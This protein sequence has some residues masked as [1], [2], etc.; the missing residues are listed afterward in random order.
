M[1]YDRKSS[2]FVLVVAQINIEVDPRSD[3]PVYKFN[4]DAGADIFFKTEYSATI[5][6]TDCFETPLE[7]KVDNGGIK[8]V[9]IGPDQHCKIAT[10]LKTVIPK[11]HY[12][13]LIGKS[14]QFPFA[15]VWP[16][17]ID[18]EYRGPWKI[19][20]T[21]RGR[22]PLRIKNGQAIAQVIIFPI[23]KA[24][25]VKSTNA[26]LPNSSRGVTGFGGVAQC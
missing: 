6:T 7:V 4:T 13:Q 20:I 14:S 10:N 17:V 8:F 3:V 1:M 11:G 26:D 19:G 24:N 18:C 23:K 21:N 16:G 9:E 2:L 25:Y 22:N 15:H 12:A 5:I